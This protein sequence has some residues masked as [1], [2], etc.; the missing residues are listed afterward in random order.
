MLNVPVPFDC[1]S[2][3]L[4]LSIASAS[5]FPAISDFVASEMVETSAASCVRKYILMMPSSKPTEP[6]SV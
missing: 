3:Q 2:A 4:L 6:T 5:A 1:A